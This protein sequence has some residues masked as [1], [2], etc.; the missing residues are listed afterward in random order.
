[1]VRPWLRARR[2]TMIITLRKSLPRSLRFQARRGILAHPRLL[3][4]ETRS[5]TTCCR[6]VR[7]IAMVGARETVQREDRPH[8]VHDGFR[9]APGGHQG[10]E[11]GETGGDDGRA[12]LNE[13]PDEVVVD[14][15]GEGRVG[16]RGDRGE[17]PDVVEA[18][19]GGDD[20]A[21][22]DLMLKPSQPKDTYELNFASG[23]HVEFP[24]NR[25]RETKR[26]EIDSEVQDSK[27]KEESR[28]VVSE[29]NFSI[30]PKVG[31]RSCREEY[32]LELNLLAGPLMAGLSSK[33]IF[34]HDKERNKPCNNKSHG[35]IGHYFEPS[36]R[37]DALVQEEN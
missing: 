3:A 29:A 28:K 32:T 4:H 19:S 7:R 10:G 35:D 5:P 18:D 12:G 22:G 25:K 11:S 14:D 13:R 20:T 36:C 33:S 34:T 37:K 31:N 6:A 27:C 9:A 17:V 30:V 24:D 23:A 26:E 16:G 21:V 8:A 2:G 1:M 15:A